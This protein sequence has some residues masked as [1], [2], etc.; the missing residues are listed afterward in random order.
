MPT[1]K[2][3]LRFVVHRLPVKKIKVDEHNIKI[4]LPWEPSLFK[5]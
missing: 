4:S 5:N 2:N 3:C 1:V